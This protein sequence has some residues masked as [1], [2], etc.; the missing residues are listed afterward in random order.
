MKK[1]IKE[2]LTQGKG[3]LRDS[4]IET[5]A[6][7]SE[8]LLCHVLN[9]S[10]V[11]LFTHSEDEVLKEDEIKYKELICKRAKRVPIQYL[12]NKQEFMSLPF[13]VNKNVLIP[14]RDTENLVELV[15]EILDKEKKYDILD[16]C[17]GSGCIGISIAYFLPKSRVI[18][19]DISKDSLKV[20]K[21][22]AKIN[23]VDDRIEFVNSDLFKNI[24]IKDKLDMIISNPPYIPTK[25]IDN[26]MEEV[27]KYEPIKALDG[28][29]DGLD[30]YRIITRE[31]IEYLKP[32]GILMFEI[33]YNQGKMVSNILKSHG[34]INVNIK[35]DLA[36]FD[37]I[38]FGI[39]G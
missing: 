27:K 32:K 34:F 28:G 2:I 8:I 29:E 9:L 39:K 17:T 31:S 7:D 26:L 12:I 36:G 25:D 23:G 37:R 16:M 19:S 38:V 6:L 5:W 21:Y 1:T 14:R 30:F 18:A 15:L 22:N 3:I 10:R 4:K 13:Y 33:G 11:Q 20:A 24:S 35:K